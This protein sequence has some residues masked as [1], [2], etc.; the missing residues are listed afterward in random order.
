VIPL[1]QTLSRIRSPEALP[2][3]QRFAGERDFRVGPAAIA[4]IGYSQSHDA[5]RVLSTL[6]AAGSPYLNRMMEALGELGDA[7]GAEL[8]NAEARKL[9]A[10]PDDPD[11]IA[12]WVDAISEAGD[13]SSYA[14]FAG[15][16][17]ALAK[18]G[19][20][21]LTGAV[22]ALSRY[23]RQTRADDESG[24]IRRDALFSLRHMVGRGVFEALVEALGERS[25][26]ARESAMAAMLQ[27]GARQCVAA[28]VDAVR[29]EGPLAPLAYSMIHDVV[30]E[31]PAG[32]EFLENIDDSQLASWWQAH[33]SRLL[34]GTVYRFGHRAWPPDLFLAASTGS[35]SAIEDLR[36]ITG[37]DFALHV[38]PQ[39]VLEGAPDPVGRTAEA[40]WAANGSRF[41]HGGLYKY[42]H[43]QDLARVFEP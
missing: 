8:L 33:E 38:D 43:R 6:I 19:D 13:R 36:V 7:R 14:D 25:Q 4:A 21:S 40:W 11:A 12:A 42:G 37:I 15:I 10:S 27:L 30:G 23:D 5:C 35:M 3:L 17:T 20:H 16:A 29:A 22:V 1:S 2:L 26:E 28:W 39:L 41:D 31:W 18:L 32:T 24:E 9:L 34:S